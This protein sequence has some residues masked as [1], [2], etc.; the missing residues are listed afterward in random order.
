MKQVE[1]G[2]VRDGITKPKRR[3]MEAVLWRL[4]KYDPSNPEID[5]LRRKL[6]IVR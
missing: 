4:E 5:I 3:R 2:T 1:G 6:G